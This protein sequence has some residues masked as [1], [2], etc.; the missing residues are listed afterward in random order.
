MAEKT[1]ALYL[2]NPDTGSIELI[3]ADDVDTR[4]A[5]G[6]KE[7]EGLK[8]NGEEWN[9]EEDLVG[10]DYAA[11]QAKQKAETDAKRAKEQGDDAP[12]TASKTA[13]KK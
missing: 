12:K 13:A 4:R 9:A 3:H 6:W 5:Q 8:A 11:D 7:P 10:Q 2:V 1:H